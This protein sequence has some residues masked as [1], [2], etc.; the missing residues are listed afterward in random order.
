VDI[1][2]HGYGHLAQVAPVLAGLTRRLP[3]LRLTIRSQLAPQVV[4]ARIK[5]E[6]QIL[7]S[8][9]DFGVC[10]RDALTVDAVATFQ[11]Y[12]RLFQDWT[13]VV[14]AA[15]EPIARTDVTL[16]LSNISFI[17]AAAAKA[18]GV[19]AI[20]MSSLDWAQVFESH[21]GHLPR[22]N[23]LAARMRQMYRSARQTIALRPSLPMR[24]LP[25]VRH[26]GPVAQS[27]QARRSEVLAK[28]GA[29]K[30]ARLVLFGFGGSVPPVPDL[31][32]I[33]SDLALLGPHAWSGQNGFRSVEEAEVPFLDLLAS[34]DLVVSKLGYGIVTETALAGRPFVGFT[35]A[36]WPEDPV[37]E[38]WIRARVP[39]AIMRGDMGRLR[40]D[41]FFALVERLLSAEVKRR[42]TMDKAKEI[43]DLL[44]AELAEA[45]GR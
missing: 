20:L 5:H 6:H 10:M 23:D 19:P 34:C 38:R 42:A 1:S 33:P 40:P 26:I 4:R 2:G 45:A 7:P 36:H 28:L 14:A 21:C 43:A 15:A 30:N 8:D 16:V 25:A 31:A 22:A 27:G 11:A 24:G 12:D 18:V 29:P 13:K 37:L 3:R 9:F 35:R 39:T 44:V 41:R 32:P 17:S